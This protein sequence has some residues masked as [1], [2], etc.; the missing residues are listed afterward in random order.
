MNNL[1]IDSNFYISIEL[2][3]PGSCAR[4]FIVVGELGIILVLPSP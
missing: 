4:G 3:Y 2:V 1:G